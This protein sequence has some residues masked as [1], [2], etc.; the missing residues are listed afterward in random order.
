MRIRRELVRSRRMLLLPT[1]D[2]LLGI[3]LFP[4]ALIA[5]G[6]MLTSA[7]WAQSSETIQSHSGPLAPFSQPSVEK[8]NV[9]G[10]VID[11]VTGDP[12][13]KALVQVYANQRRMTF[14]DG[15]GRFQLEGIGAGSYSVT[16]EKP[17]Y[18][19][20]QELMHGGATYV[21]V[22]PKAAPAV[23][24]KLTPEAVLAGTVKSTAGVPLEHVTLHLTYLEI[25]EGRRRW[26]NRGSGVTDVDG[27][28][29]IAHLRPGEY[30]LF[31]SP[32]AVRFETILDSDERPKTGYPG[33]YY[34]S[35]PDLASATAIELKAG[36][37][38]E[39]NFSLNEVPVY[40][41][42]GTISGYGANQGVGIQIF[43]QSGTQV[44]R[45]IGFSAENGRFDVRPLAPG[46]YVIKAFSTAASNQ[47]VRAELHFH[48]AADLHNLH[49]VL[50]PNPSIPVI[51]QMDAVGPRGK[52]VAALNRIS[53]N[54]PPLSVRLIGSGL[55]LNESFA[56]FDNAQDRQTLFL[57]NVEPGHY[58]AVI[59][60]RD[61]WYV[62]SA[63]YGQTNL[64]TDDLVLAPGAPPGSLNI[65]LRNDSAALSGT[66]DV[67]EGFT[68]QVT[69]VAI[70]QRGAKA[71]PGIS[72]WYPP[73]EKT[74]EPPQFLLES[75][76]PGDYE[77]FAFDHTDGIEYTK[78][79]VLES[80]ASQGTQLTLSPNQ[81][82]K[83]RL[84]LIRIAES[85]K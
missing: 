41:I 13:R 69:I 75:L 77:V 32:H 59:D 49:L 29:R 12:I 70:P 20:E 74:A 33:M 42:S 51:V 72:Y 9:T 27:R 39:A 17:G 5:L 66:V 38:S 60:A 23:M 10:T 52:G 28:F 19:N 24:V 81:R 64:L 76:A 57:H 34:A 54:G 53:T 61:G 46:N 84:Q 68:S 79:D 63:E 6:C 65:V 22:G 21:E 18:F 67:P 55:G 78:R 44:D 26:D 8:F 37:Q 11:A 43:D 62:A 3:L 47:P 82:T 83:V 15:D 1:A 50:A 40:A 2:S 16:A 80:F 25:R 71:S 85:T 56:S 36:E 30:Y 45:G 4:V 7:I 58:S 14:S 48:L 73:R 35:A 31:A